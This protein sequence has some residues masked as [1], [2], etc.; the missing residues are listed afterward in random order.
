M[1]VDD[2]AVVRGL[3]TQWIAAEADMQVVASA[4]NGRMAIDQAAAAAPDVAILDIEMPELDGISALP[5]LMERKPDLAVIMASAQTRRHAEI[6]IRALMLGAADYVPKPQSMTGGNQVAAFRRELI[7][8]IREIGTRR[9]T[10][11]ARSRGTRT[12]GRI[13]P[14]GE[15]GVAASHEAVDQ[16]LRPFPHA[17]P[18]ALLIGASTGGPQALTTLLSRLGP[19]VGKM[20]V[21]ITQHMPP[22]FTTIIAQHLTRASGIVARE[23]IDGEPVL[24]GR[25]YVAPG[26]M[27]LRVER[28]AGKVVTALSDE[29]PV[30]F[31]KP[32]IDLLFSSAARVW[33]RGIMALVLTGMGYDGA[34]GARDIVASGGSVMAQ[35]EASSVVWGMPGAVVQAGLCCAILPVDAMATRLNE[36][37]VG[38]A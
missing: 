6:S 4:W 8:K 38:V 13:Q 15:Q 10:S 11:R 12:G 20:P 21:L 35:D 18:R 27:H 30:N 14:V 29:P 22:M 17:V 9:R 34:A 33:G 32:A 25:I 23:A 28:R 1:V 5:Q 31:C 24:A 2:S 7:D 36:L 37:I 26:G 3:F 19:V 16:P